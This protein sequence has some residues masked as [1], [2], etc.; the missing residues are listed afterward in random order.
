MNKILKHSIFCFAAASS[1]ALV[2][3]SSDDEIASAEADSLGAYGN[4]YFTETSLTAELDPEEPTIYTVALKRE[5]ATSAVTVP[6]VV[7]GADSVVTAS[8]A[9]FVAGEDSTTVTID[10]SKAEIG[11][12][13]T[14]TVKAANTIYMTPFELTV[15]RVK[16]NEAGSYFDDEGNLITS[17]AKY[18]DDLVTTFW[19]I[20]NTTQVVKLQER[21]DKPGYFRIVNAYAGGYAYN[22]EGDYDADN[23]YYIIIDASDPEKVYIP[24]KCEQGTDWGYGNFIVWSMAGYYIANGDEESA[25]DY[26]GKYEDGVITFP[27]GALLFG[28]AGYNDGGMYAS[29]NNG[30]FRLEVEA[31]HQAYVADV[32]SAD[33]TWETV[34]SEGAFTSSMLGNQSTAALLKGGCVNTTDSCDKTFNATYGTAYKIVSPYAEGYDIYF[35]VNADGDVTN[36]AGTQPTG[37]TAMGDSVY[38]YINASASSFSEKLTTLNI[39]FT[40]ADG[41]I[42]YG[43][44]DE[45]LSNITWTQ[46][47]TGTYTYLADVWGDENGNAPSDAGLSLLKRDDKEDTYKITNW[48]MGVDY[49]F[50]WNHE[51]NEVQVSDQ[52]TG[53]TDDSYGDMYVIELNQ[54]AS[55]TASMPSSYYDPATQT[56]HFYVI[57]YVSAGYFGYGEETLTLDSASAAKAHKAHK[58]TVKTMKKAKAKGVKRTYKFCTTK[59]SMKESLK[60]AGKPL[61]F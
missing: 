43:T 57:Y 54:Y 58:S 15:T 14:A 52:Y 48:L 16:W 5:D 4:I 12:T 6:M 61:A 8:E 21:D 55:S 46:T 34:F 36:P 37:L 32:T 51:T 31:I 39:T 44:A 45:V 59:R 23:D 24:E 29:N 2:S 1:V 38:A 47:T 7:E 19:S 17:Y 9:H 49:V 60:N 10:F 42:T 40:N 28:M 25:T 50:T 33:F 18:T 53:Y 41:S 11:V 27:A 3:C 20:D 56:F 26:Y 35:G 13:Y 22:E 30:A